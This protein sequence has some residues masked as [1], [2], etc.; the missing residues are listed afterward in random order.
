MLTQKGLERLVKYT[1]RFGE[2]PAFGRSN[3]VVCCS[4]W[5]VKNTLK[6]EGFRY[7]FIEDPEG[8]GETIMVKKDDP[9]YSHI[10]TKIT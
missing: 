4:K 9:K 8:S 1:D 7:R 2:S 5:E 10:P 6:G 3:Q